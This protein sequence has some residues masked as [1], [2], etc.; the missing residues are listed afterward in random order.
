M[1]NVKMSDCDFLCTFAILYK[2]GM[3]PGK[4]EGKKKV[5]HLR[6]ASRR[7]KDII[8]PCLHAHHLMIE[9]SGLQML[10]E[11]PPR[12]LRIGTNHTDWASLVVQ[13][14]KNLPVMQGTWV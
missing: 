5:Y 11:Y 7:I 8:I 12:Y 9:S 4:R 14:V 6:L 2:Q 3:Y 10:P 13:T 1:K